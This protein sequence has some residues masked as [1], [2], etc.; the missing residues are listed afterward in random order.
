MHLVPMPPVIM[1]SDAGFTLIEALVVIGLVAVMAGATVP[2]VA[3]GLARYSLTNAGQQVASTLR[4]ARFH[5]V[6]TNRNVRI[7]INVATG[8]YHREAFVAGAWVRVNR[9]GELDA[10]GS[11]TFTLPNGISFAAGTPAN[12]EFDTQGRLAGGAALT[13]GVTNGNAAYDRNVVIS[14]RGRTTID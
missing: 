9:A 2:A 14:A 10:G 7:V 4:A 12:V 6:G 11:E 3:G 13:V 1:K 8:N 5:A